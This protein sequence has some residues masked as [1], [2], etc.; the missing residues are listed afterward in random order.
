MAS[1]ISAG[2]STGTALN[3]TGDTSGI[4]QLASNNGTVGLTLSTSQQVGIGTSSPISSLDVRG[5]ISC[6]QTTNPTLF[7]QTD[8]SYTHAGYMQYNNSGAKFIV[9]SYSNDPLAFVTNNTEQM[10]IDTSGN[11]GVGTTSPSTYGKFAVYNSASDVESAVVTGGANYATYRLQNSTN[12]YSMQIR[13]DLSN[14]WTLRD[15]TAGANRLAVDTSGN[16]LVGCTAIPTTPGNIGA[17]FQ[18]GISVAG[19]QTLTMRTNTTANY[20]AAYFYNPNGLVG[21]IRLSGSATLYST[22]SDYRLKENVAPMTGALEAVSKLK[23]CTYTWKADGSNGQGFIAH[24]LAEIC[25]DAV[26]GE[27]DQMFEDGT[28]KPQAIDT[29]FLVATLVAAIQEQQAL[30]TQLQ[31]DVAAL[32]GAK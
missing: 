19:S 14:A 2:T 10:R 20:E 11:V 18:N 29:S 16:L 27:K 5:G 26:S 28:I 8:T 9:G 21:Y 15:E 1:I 4:L 24:E 23:P 17:A 22:S 6:I 32:K 25:P 31:A 12:R 30:I 3:L 7:A 13:T